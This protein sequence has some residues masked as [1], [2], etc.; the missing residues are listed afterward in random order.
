M[1]NVLLGIIVFYIFFRL[2]TTLI[3]PKI[4]RYRIEKYKE[5]MRR[6]NPELFKNKDKGYTGNIHPAL[7]Q[8]YK[9]EDNN[10][11]NNTK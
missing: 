11:N 2:L 10:I 1:I 9:Q 4:T 7:K 3:I 5:K 8:Y 6:E